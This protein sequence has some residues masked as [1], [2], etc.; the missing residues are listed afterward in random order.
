VDRQINVELDEMA[1]PTASDVYVM[2]IPGGVEAG[3]THNVSGG[4][5][6]KLYS[7]DVS[8]AIRAPRK[9]RDRQR[10]FFIALTRS[11]EV[12]QRDVE[13]QIDFNYPTI[14]AANA[15]IVAETTSTYGFT[16]PLKFASVDPFRQAPSELFL[17]N[18][19]EQ[20]AAI[21]RRIHFRGARRIV[22]RS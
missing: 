7:V 13:A 18:P 15:Y 8:I 22:V 17:G 9:P 19:G 1:P 6:D 16:E 14:D 5:I 2:V 10:D 4:V 3:P 12:Y 21:V 20:V 11:F